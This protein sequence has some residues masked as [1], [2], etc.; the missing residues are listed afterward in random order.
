MKTSCITTTCTAYK[1]SPRDHP[2]GPHCSFDCP[3]CEGV[4]L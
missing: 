1:C 4:V 2:H 3:T